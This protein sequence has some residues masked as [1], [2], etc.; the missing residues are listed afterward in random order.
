M[1]GG[2]SVANGFELP[3][4]TSVIDSDG[5]TNRQWLQWFDRAHSIVFSQQ[6]SGP[7]ASRPQSRLWIGRQYF[8]TTLGKPVYVFG[9]NPA[10]WVDGSGTVV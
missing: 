5:A 7:T 9:V 8:D 10:V 2:V 3:S 6:Q 4:N 1:R